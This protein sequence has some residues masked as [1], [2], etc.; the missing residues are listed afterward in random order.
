MATTKGREREFI[1]WPKYKASYFRAFQKMLDL[2]VERGKPWTHGS[3][4][5]DVYNMWMEYDI[6]PGQM[7]LF[8]ED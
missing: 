7:D 6:L 4:P 2:R 3:T 8:E 5:Q 1:R